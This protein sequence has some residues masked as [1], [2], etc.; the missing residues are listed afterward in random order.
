METIA[1]NIKEVRP[2]M[3]T[4]V[5]RLLEK[6]YDKIMAKGNELTG[7]KRTLFLAPSNLAFVMIR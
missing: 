1:D 7:I 6:I 4:S 2:T 3:F 5:P